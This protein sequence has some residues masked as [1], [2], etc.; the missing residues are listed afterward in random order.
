MSGLVDAH[1]RPL[2]ASAEP[3]IVAPDGEP[4]ASKRETLP[5]ARVAFRFLVL[6]AIANGWRMPPP[7]EPDTAVVEIPVGAIVELLQERDVLVALLRGRDGFPEPCVKCDRMAEACTCDAGRCWVCSCDDEHACEGGCTWAD[8][9]KRICSRCVG[10][11]VAE[12][13]VR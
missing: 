13:L 2:S 5:N 9:E 7:G 1:G 3:D 12:D 11:I 4:L 10:G 8:E 6:E